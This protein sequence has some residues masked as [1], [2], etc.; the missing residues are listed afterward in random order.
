VMVRTCGMEGDGYDGVLEAEDISAHALCYIPH[1]HLI[2]TQKDTGGRIR[3]H[4]STIVM[5]T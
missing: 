4:V 5:S 1:P 3:T 2:H